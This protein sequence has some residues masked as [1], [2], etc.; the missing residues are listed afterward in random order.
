MPPFRS[1]NDYL[2]GFQVTPAA[3]PPPVQPA[4]VEDSYGLGYGDSY[5]ANA[6]QYTP[7]QNPPQQF[8]PNLQ[9]GAAEGQHLFVAAP[10][11]VGPQVTSWG[12]VANSAYPLT[13]L[14]QEYGYQAPPPP[15]PQFGGGTM[16]SAGQIAN[17]THPRQVQGAISNMMSQPVTD[18]MN[19]DQYKNSFT[20][21]PNSGYGP[22]PIFGP[23]TDKPWWESQD[24][25]EQ[26]WWQDQLSPIDPVM[27]SQYGVDFIRSGYN[28]PEKT[29]GPFDYGSYR[30]GAEQARQFQEETA[31]A[32]GDTVGPVLN[33]IWDG[34]D[35]AYGPYDVVTGANALTP[36]QGMTRDITKMGLNDVL[37]G[38]R[39]KAELVDPKT[40]EWYRNWHDPFLEKEWVKNV[41]DL[42]D[43]ATEGFNNKVGEFGGWLNDTF[44]DALRNEAR[45]QGD[46]W[47]DM[48]AAMDAAPVLSGMTDFVRQ[49]GSGIKDKLVGQDTVINNPLD[50]WVNGGNGFKKLALADTITKIYGDKATPIR[51]TWGDH[52]ANVG[53]SPLRTL[54]G[55]D[56]LHWLNTQQGR[57]ALEK[58]LKFGPNN[59]VINFD[60]AH[61]L[62]WNDFLETQPGLLAKLGQEYQAD[63]TAILDIA[64]I[65]A[66]GAGAALRAA[67]APR[68]L[69]RGII[70]TGKLADS[71]SILF[72]DHLGG[73]AVSR[74]AGTIG[75][76]LTPEAVKNV[77]KANAAAE[78][79][80]GVLNDY[81]KGGIV[82]GASGVVPAPVPTAFSPAAVGRAMAAA[83]SVS[84][85]TGAA[86][87][88][89][90]GAA[91]AG[92]PGSARAAAAAA[93]LASIPP[94]ALPSPAG[95]PLAQLE[96][97]GFI[98]TPHHTSG[99][100]RQGQVVTEVIT[101]VNEETGRVYYIEG[102]IQATGDMVGGAVDPEIPVWRP[103][104][105]T[106]DG[107]RYI[108]DSPMTADEAGQMIGWNHD[109]VNG[110]AFDFSWIDDAEAATD[111]AADAM[112]PETAAAIRA[113][114]EE[115]LGDR[116]TLTPEALDDGADELD[117]I[118]SLEENGY[119]V[120]RQSRDDSGTHG[121]A[122]TETYSVEKDGNV[123]IL[124]AQRP[125]G[126][127][128][129]RS[130]VPFAAD[131]NQPYWQAWVPQPDGSYKKLQRPNGRRR[132]SMTREQAEELLHRY[133]EGD[134]NSP[135][136]SNADADAFDEEFN[137]WWRNATPEERAAFNAG[138]DMVAPQMSPLE[139]LSA[140]QGT[141]SLDD[142]D[143]S[144]L[145]P[146]AEQRMAEYNAAVQRITDGNGTPE[147]WHIIYTEDSAGWGADPRP[148]DSG[149]PDNYW[150]ETLQTLPG[151]T[152]EIKQTPPTEEDLLRLQ[153]EMRWTDDESSLNQDRIRMLEEKGA[154]LTED[155][156]QELWELVAKEYGYDGPPVDPKMFMDPN[157]RQ[158][159]LGDVNGTGLDS[160]AIRSSMNNMGLL[161]AVARIADELPELEREEVFALLRNKNTNLK[162]KMQALEEWKQ[163]Q[164][165][166]TQLKLDEAMAQ[167][168]RPLTQA[169]IDEF[170]LGPYKA[171][172][173]GEE[174]LDSL[175]LNSLD[176]VDIED[177]YGMGD[178]GDPIVDS[179]RS[180]AD[181]VPPDRIPTEQEYIAAVTRM[182][183][184]TGTT[185]D[186][187][188]IAA[189]DKNKF[190]PDMGVPKNYKSPYE[191]EL[192]RRV[193][194]TR[195][196][197]PDGTILTGDIPPTKTS[198]A[199]DE[200]TGFSSNSAMPPSEEV[201]HDAPSAREIERLRQH[202][203]ALRM[204]VRRAHEMGI[205][206]GDNGVSVA[207]KLFDVLGQ[208][209][210]SYNYNTRVIS[211]W[212]GEIERRAADLGETAD[213]VLRKTVNEEV[214][215]A[216]RA[217]G[218]ISDDEWAVLVAWAKKNPGM[219]EDE[220]GLYTRVW[221]EAGP[222][223]YDA[224]PSAEAHIE[225]EMVAKA[226]ARRQA[227]LETASPAARIFEK[228][229]DFIDRMLSVFRSQPSARTVLRDTN[230]GKMIPTWGPRN[231]SER[232]NSLVGFDQSDE[233]KRGFSQN[234]LGTENGG[235]TS[236]PILYG[237]AA[238]KNAAR[239]RE[240]LN[241]VF[242]RAKE[243]G[244]PINEN[245]IEVRIKDAIENGLKGEWNNN[246][247]VLTLWLD[248]IEAEA[249]KGRSAEQI[250]S[251]TANEELIHALRRSG[252]IS[253]QEWGV[254]VDWAKKNN[255]MS[256]EEIAAYTRHWEE[257]SEAKWDLFSG[258][259]D[260][261]ADEMVAKAVANRF[262]N[263]AINSPVG[264]IMA[265]LRDFVDRM[266]SA[267][268]STPSAETVMRNMN[269]GKMTPTWEPKNPGERLRNEIAAAQADE[270]EDR[271]TLVRTGRRRSETRR[272]IVDRGPAPAPE[273]RK[274]YIEVASPGEYLE[275]EDATHI[276]T[277]DPATQ[278]YIIRRRTD[279]QP[280]YV[281]VTAENRF[282][283]EIAMAEGKKALEDLDARRAA[284]LDAKLDQL[285]LSPN[286]ATEVASS[287][288]GRD[289]PFRRKYKTR[290][291]KDSTAWHSRTE[292]GWQEPN[293]E[294]REDLQL[295]MDHVERVT[296]QAEFEAGLRDL[297][298][299][300]GLGTDEEGRGL[301]TIFW[302]STDRDGTPVGEAWENYK[303]IV[304]N[305]LVNY[306]PEVAQNTLDMIRLENHTIERAGD[307]EEILQMAYSKG[308]TPEEVRLMSTG[309]FAR[310]A[311]GKAK[312]FVTGEWRK[313]VTDPNGNPLRRPVMA[314]VS[315][316]FVGET[317]SWDKV[318]V[319]VL[320]GDVKHLTNGG[321][322]KYNGI[323]NS[324]Q[325]ADHAESAKPRNASLY[326][327]YSPDEILEAAV[328]GGDAI[329]PG[330][331]SLPD[332]FSDNPGSQFITSHQLPDGTQTIMVRDKA[333]GVFRIVDREGNLIGEGLSPKAARN[334]AD[335]AHVAAGH[336]PVDGPETLTRWEFEKATTKRT[337]SYGVNVNAKNGWMT[338]VG[339][340]SSGSRVGRKLEIKRLGAYFAPRGFDAEAAG[341]DAAYLIKNQ[342]S[343]RH[344]I[345][346]AR[347]LEDG[348]LEFRV[349]ANRQ[350][351]VRSASGRHVNVRNHHL[352]G[353][354]NDLDVA[355][356]HIEVLA[357]RSRAAEIDELPVIDRE[358][359]T[360]EAT[361][362]GLT[363]EQI[364]T[365]SE[366]ELAA[367]SMAQAEGIAK[368]K[369]PDYT[370]RRKTSTSFHV[371]DGNGKA[372]GMIFN[373]EPNSFFPR[374]DVPQLDEIAQ[375]AVKQAEEVV[376]G[377]ADSATKSGAKTTPK[378]K[379]KATTVELE[380]R[381]AIAKAAD[382]EQAVVEA[383]AAAAKKKAPRG[384]K[385]ARE[386][387]A[388]DAEAVAAA[389]AGVG[390]EVRTVEELTEA[391]DITPA[392]EPRTLE[393]AKA[394]EKDSP[395][396][397]IQAQRGGT[398]KI[399]FYSKRTGATT[400]SMYAYDKNTGKLLSSE[401]IVHENLQERNAKYEQFMSEV[402]KAD[403]A[404]VT[405]VTQVNQVNVDIVKQDLADSHDVSQPLVVRQAKIEEARE[406][407]QEM[408]Y[409]DEDAF[410]AAHGG[411]KGAVL[412]EAAEEGD[413]PA[414]RSLLDV[415]DA[416]AANQERGR[417][418]RTL[419]DQDKTIRTTQNNMRDLESITD[420]IAEFVGEDIEGLSAVDR[421][422]LDQLLEEA[423]AL[424]K[425]IDEAAKDLGMTKKQIQQYTVGNG[426]F[427]SPS[428]SIRSAKKTAPGE[429]PAWKNPEYNP[430]A[431]GGILD[432]IG[433][434]LRN[435]KGAELKHKAHGRTAFQDAA[436]LSVGGA[437]AV[438]RHAD[439]MPGT[440]GHTYGIMMTK[441][442]EEGL[443]VVYTTQR[444]GTRRLGDITFETEDAAREAWR[445]GHKQLTGAT[446]TKT[447][448]V[449]LKD[450]KRKIFIAP[451]NHEDWQ[452]FLSLD[453]DGVSGFV[454]RIIREE[455]GIANKALTDAWRPGA[456]TN[457]QGMA[458]KAYATYLT[459]LRSM[460]LYGRHRMVSYPM[461]QVVGN[462]A[463]GLV[464]AP[465]SVLHYWK[466]LNFMRT[467]ARNLQ[468]PDSK[469]KTLADET[470]SA[471]SLGGT[472]ALNPHLSPRNTMRDSLRLNQ[473]PL[474]GDKAGPF[475]QALQKIL[476]S[477]AS[478]ELGDA[479]D[480][481]FREAVWMDATAREFYLAKRELLNHIKNAAARANRSRGGV[482][483][484][485]NDQIE[486]AILDLWQSS[487]TGLASGSDVKRA[488]L[489]AAGP[490]P[491]NMTE[492]GNFA[493][494][495]GRDWMY[496]VR[497]IDRR[498]IKEVNRIAFSFENKYF[499]NVLN[500]FFMFH[501]WSSRA[502]MLYAT[503]AIRKPWFGHAWQKYMT[504][505]RREYE[506]HPEKYSKYEAGFWDLWTTD[507]GVKLAIDPISLLRTYITEPGYLYGQKDAADRTLLGKALSNPSFEVAGMELPNPVA[508]MFPV[509]GPMMVLGALGA[510]GKDVDVPDAFG[511]NGHATAVLR[512]MQIGSKLGIPVPGSKDP[513]GNLIPVEGYTPDEI[514]KWAMVKFNN[515]FPGVL[516]KINSDS[517]LTTTE[518]RTRAH[519]QAIFGAIY[520]D[521]ENQGLTGDELMD[522]FEEASRDPANEYY[523]AGLEQ[524]MD[525]D[526]IDFVMKLFSPVYSRT[527]TSGSDI[528]RF[529]DKIAPDGTVP[530][531][532]GDGSGATLPGESGF[533]TDVDLRNTDE[534]E[535][536]RARQRMNN[537]INEENTNIVDLSM[538]QDVYY[539][540]IPEDLR[541]VNDTANGIKYGNGLKHDV[542]IGGI[543][544]PA[545]SLQFLSW[546]ERNLLSDR[547][548]KEE[549]GKEGIGRLQRAQELQMTMLKEDPELADYL[550]FKKLA[551]DYEG[552]AAA[553]IN[554]L[555]R[556]N[557]QW[558]DWILKQDNQEMAYTSKESWEILNQRGGD[559]FGPE[560]NAE[561]GI[562]P[563][564]VGLGFEDDSQTL[565]QWYISELEG[566]EEELNEYKQ[567]VVDDIEKAGM[568]WKQI[569]ELTGDDELFQDIVEASAKG[570]RF[571][572]EDEALYA[573]LKEFMTDGG[574]G[575]RYWLGL[576]AKD[577]LAWMQRQREL[578]P[579]ADISVDNYFLESDASWGMEERVDPNATFD[580]LTQGPELINALGGVEQ[581]A[582]P[583]MTQAPDGPLGSA[584]V[585]V[586]DKPITIRSA[587][588]G[589]PVGVVK[590][591][592]RL[593]VLETD[594][595]WTKVQ[596]PGGKV[597]WIESWLLMK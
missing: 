197:L 196:I 406:L 105:Q 370:V 52:I 452:E 86:G 63:P 388:K 169:D 572:I 377:A 87:A 451:K 421:A 324:N 79:A 504:E 189:Y 390:G 383:A 559:M 271:L 165:P 493:D 560:A 346:D 365:M 98:I 445:L 480:V 352:V 415:G 22:D 344:F 358:I 133:H 53:T 360:L 154:N 21:V 496:A 492:L 418:R 399:T 175:G 222:E 306:G 513:D 337:D 465:G 115:L 103:V 116:L 75:T 317:E 403:E 83:G 131:P 168:P 40:D 384:T 318:V 435:S 581:P 574:D 100:I 551:E 148:A 546:Q 198:R 254:L 9:G 313:I 265:K 41:N 85:P 389:D 34:T 234:S 208:T 195:E 584:A 343:G 488:L 159:F 350:G 397:S 151:G 518:R 230:A 130:G 106:P 364:A 5:A 413:A 244:I 516:N 304:S 532:L 26:R 375:A 17:E 416:G 482:I 93:A 68:W 553:F 526:V 585:G 323:I 356:D 209:L 176:E 203:N 359:K 533:G 326:E 166:M 541:S 522:I 556:N 6:T 429:I 268:R 137:N 471:L 128:G 162:Q 99:E 84:P 538:K 311:K 597:A 104:V 411:V 400:S 442:A 45:R 552:G 256:A 134:F 487:P 61:E 80:T 536:S 250:L 517:L 464:A 539:N 19:W 143:T 236:R 466:P 39:W 596:L 66:P 446:L 571:R 510:L 226:F 129:F 363:G 301:A 243:M 288:P 285:R 325:F 503:E 193:K 18:N 184:G 512:M 58:H 391:G 528:V 110:E 564:L 241:L 497:E 229:S 77:R 423:K 135:S 468:G 328:E 238:A 594:G 338:M 294:P 153:E 385:K 111:E 212:L 407:I 43:R 453:H 561:L 475:A 295:M 127:S 213:L 412:E 27:Q 173:T 273:V 494:R 540:A 163:R 3:A 331:T 590:T 277:R 449:A 35:T 307:L 117:N 500:K 595:D 248:N 575:N 67:G 545:Q 180:A 348:T 398:G 520:T 570:E 353:T 48:V 57:A 501:Y 257:G 217:S 367:H 171:N 557:P 78:I 444:G 447:E 54:W 395:D 183:D 456:M 233:V 276:L 436:N 479:A 396:V 65:V 402:D 340:T 312:M 531:P 172:R 281:A 410:I 50:F 114:M 588:D 506:A 113:D 107:P 308:L 69:S 336:A 347:K 381:E 251:D 335:A 330:T 373:D 123:Y 529:L 72:M 473:A 237:A 245:G 211:L 142:I 521:P 341:F 535:S 477:R 210:G 239:H 476:I 286:R 297:A 491:M 568:L 260:F 303:N 438:T 339:R 194:L 247:R 334:K 283:P 371:V 262:T 486:R 12:Q 463:S 174:S 322:R 219:T 24:V 7:Q 25:H 232:I 161:D 112:D 483:A 537:V 515:E 178:F 519:R 235:L 167:G 204:V 275:L 427:S 221:D 437:E 158:S 394:L 419:S 354:F 278:S 249:R 259:D 320:P 441:D 216:L 443:N 461:Q 386:K 434:A 484:L 192:E 150:E 263:Q 302:H 270:L 120:T 426:K 489:D 378:R 549:L 252:A 140:R 269:T 96:S 300:A 472:P 240:A 292:K 185:D 51:D 460:Y 231:A 225:D 547:F 369:N 227:M 425:N 202:N 593:G 432:N 92:A 71:G 56:Y 440:W 74:L 224:F 310:G 376:E 136:M 555:A 156:L 145:D 126:P 592:I 280:S 8:T 582:V 589:A 554:Q 44:G 478:K 46:D 95:Q 108:G 430:G 177:D 448:A 97:N 187:T 544:Y 282:N 548:L 15:E 439:N 366:E 60:E 450:A 182:M 261:L 164:D 253:E 279:G 327:D 32:V 101:V 305:R 583:N 514:V 481:A 372:V 422:T 550:G 393:A 524:V 11:V 332:G 139:N 351:H 321:K 132:V 179:L 345:I 47:Q 470:R 146:L 562:T 374:W 296:D 380:E 62:I 157:W 228:L 534:I 102:R 4:P 576:G 542:V 314:Q 290:T 459:Y 457:K 586:S 55:D 508:A 417:A 2:T 206:V 181:E 144:A 499:D 220:I 267:F 408:G 507:A 73:K 38:D 118:F 511:L 404:Q 188:T 121:H 205:P 28:D 20:E 569:I 580:P 284:E 90:P 349:V 152:N 30:E 414:T 70:T 10:G 37:S 293:R 242:R 255:V 299:T 558:Q 207:I 109:S 291:G 587:P 455:M 124:T 223:K 577:Y 392:G 563:S 424:K 272:R 199:I 379:K 76:A 573:A 409:A 329:K 141:A 287:K 190:G 170:P 13:D 428:M 29:E 498:G 289:T 454:D 566:E 502:T 266:V 527:E 298:S 458:E 368:A 357:D 509:P 420:E 431:P 49:A 42:N 160:G 264:K 474:A 319:K 138:E 333:D 94:S 33:T 215:H 579:T 490:S 23:G 186:W 36:D 59:M 401:D 147:D 91:G 64:G 214:F 258:L 149:S 591:G 525:K 155:E 433:R 274:E 81:R 246:D 315:G 89:T 309:R 342:N 565:G 485:T 469:I 355:I 200:N 361:E 14:S 505:A 125:E 462:S 523:Q 387:A 88:V 567:G 1:F 362:D 82:G 405:Q 218:A 16:L 578:D 543:L 316:P 31:R 467:R 382:E 201:V 191:L 495:M 530:Y 122:S 119:T